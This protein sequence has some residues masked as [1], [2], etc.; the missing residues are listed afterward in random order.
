MQTNYLI[1]IGAVFAAIALVIAGSWY[2]VRQMERQ[3]AQTNA[4]ASTGQVI[5]L[6]AGHG[7]SS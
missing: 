5:I 1:K 2:T 7:A 3:T 4:Q 6:D